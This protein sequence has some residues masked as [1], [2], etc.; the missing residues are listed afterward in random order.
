[1]SYP[2]DIE[3]YTTEE[4]LVEVKRRLACKARGQCH[5]CLRPH[6]TSPC[7]FPNVHKGEMV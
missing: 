1:M 6:D 5:Y 2:K 4:L 7:K 3:D